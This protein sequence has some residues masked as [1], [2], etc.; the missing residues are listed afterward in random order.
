MITSTAQPFSTEDS[1]HLFPPQAS[2][3]V[4]GWKVVA[5]EQQAPRGGRFGGVTHARLEV[6]LGQRHPQLGRQVA[7]T[8]SARVASRSRAREMPRRCAPPP[9]RPTPPGR[10]SIAGRVAAIAASTRSRGSGT[11]VFVP[12]VTVIGRSVFSRTV[13]HGTPERSRLL[14]Q[15]AGIGDDHAC[16]LHE[17]QH[18]R[19]RQRLEQP[20]LAEREPR[21]RQSLRRARVSREHDGRLLGQLAERVG[22][23]REARGV[24]DVRR[25]VQ[26]HDDRRAARQSDRLAKPRAVAPRRARRTAN[27]SSRCR[28]TRSPRRAL[29]PFA[30]SRRRRATERKGGRRD[31]R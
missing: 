28:R 1:R 7:P 17:I 29:P 9:A 30:A 20:G 10:R 22:D 18:F 15:T 24:I 3:G 16:P 31:G 12:S 25:T 23:C 6:G 19:I 4:V 11:S 5:H 13:R 14:L 26:R 21:G 8:G 2:H 27:R